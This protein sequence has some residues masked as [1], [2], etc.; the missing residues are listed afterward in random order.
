MGRLPTPDELL[1][2]RYEGLVI[3]YQWLATQENAR[4]LKQSLKKSSAKKIF[5]IL[6]EV[7]HA[8]SDLAYGQAC[9]T[10]FPDNIVSHRLM[11]SGTPYRSDGRRMLGNWI[12]Y[13]VRE[14]NVY[15]YEPDF[16]YTLLNALNDEVIPPFSFVTLA[17]EFTYRQGEA[18]YEGRSLLILK[19][20]MNYQKY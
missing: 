6:D 3:S 14:N 20:K 7:H 2:K 17:G 16:S 11:T 13:Q 18:V 10:A 1:Q 15:Q 9:E 4:T 12:N 19:M 8:S 5:L